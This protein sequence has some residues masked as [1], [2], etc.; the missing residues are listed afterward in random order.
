VGENA[1]DTVPPYQVISLLQDQLRIGGFVVV[2][3]VLGF[4]VLSVF[5]ARIRIHQAVKLGE[6]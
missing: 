3:L 1:V 5:L 6:E 4:V 2:M